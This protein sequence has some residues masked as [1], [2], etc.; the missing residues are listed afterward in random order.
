MTPDVCVTPYPQKSSIG[1]SEWPEFLVSAEH[2][3]EPINGVQFLHGVSG[4]GGLSHGLSTDLYRAFHKGRCFEL[5]IKQSGTEP[6]VTDPPIKTLTAAQQNQLTPT[7]SKVLHSF[8][9]LK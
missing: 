3:A 5:A 7:M 4:E 6:H 1:V 2:S 9:F 8:R